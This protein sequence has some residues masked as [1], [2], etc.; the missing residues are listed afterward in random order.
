MSIDVHDFLPYYPNEIEDDF[1]QNIYD[2]KEFYD[3]R[4]QL[5]EINLPNQAKFELMKHQIIGNRYINSHTPYDRLFVNHEMG[6]GKCVLGETKITL[7]DNSTITIKELW[8]K[9]YDQNNVYLQTYFEDW[10]VPK[11]SIYVKAFDTETLNTIESNVIKLYRQYIRENIVVVKTNTYSISMT[12]A[13]KIFTLDGWKS[14]HELQL[15]MA[16]ATMFKNVMTFEAIRAIELVNY[17]G[18]VYDLEIDTYHTYIANHIITHNTCYAI[19]IIKE[20]MQI[21]DTVEKVYILSNSDKLCNNFK[22]E[23]LYKCVGNFQLDDDNFKKI[24]KFNTFTKF[25]KQ[26]KFLTNDQLNLKFS[27]TIFILDEVHH[28]HGNLTHEKKEKKKL[29]E[30]TYEQIHRLLHA[31]ENSRQILLSGTAMQNSSKE[32]IQIMN[33][34]LPLDYQLDD[35]FFIRY[36]INDYHIKPELLSDFKNHFKGNVTYLRADKSIVNVIEISNNLIPLQ[37]EFIKWATHNNIMSKFQSEIY[38]LVRRKIN[39]NNEQKNSMYSNDVQ[40]TLYVCDEDINWNKEE[41]GFLKKNYLIKREQF[42]QQFEKDKRWK[43]Q[44]EIIDYLNEH[45]TTYFQIIQYILNSPEELI[46]VYCNLVVGSGLKT[47][48]YFLSKVGFSEFIL[49]DST[50][51]V[52]DVYKYKLK[53]KEKR[54]ISTTRSRKYDA[55]RGGL[56]NLFEENLKYGNQ[57]STQ[58]LS[59]LIEVFNDP[60]NVNGE[61]I[62]II[63]GSEMISEGFSLKNIQQ[64]HIA[65]P[66]WNWAQTSQAIARGLRAHSHDELLKF[67]PDKNINVKLFLHA[68]IPQNLQAISDSI[69]LYK[70]QIS[71]EK[72]SGILE[73]QNIIREMSFDCQ[74]N[75]Y[76]NINHIP[77]QC[78]GIINIDPSNNLDYSTYNLYYVNLTNIKNQIKLYFKEFFIAHVKDIFNYLQQYDKTINYFNMCQALYELIAQNEIVEN[79][80]E[81][82]CFLK[83]ENNILYL[84]PIA[85]NEN[86]MLNNYYT[87]NPTILIPVKKKELI[88]KMYFQNVAKALQ[89]FNFTEN[90]FYNILT[91][92]MVEYLIEQSFLIDGFKSKQIQNY[93]SPYLKDNRNIIISTYLQNKE[94][95][96]LRCMDKVTKIWADCDQNVMQIEIKETEKQPIYGIYKDKKFCIKYDNPNLKTTD[97]R[98]HSKGRNCET[99]KIGDLNY[100]L[101]ELKLGK[102]HRM[103]VSEFQK[104]YTKMSC[105]IFDKKPINELTQNEKELF[106]Y[107]FKS[108]ATKTSKC[109]LI[110]DEFKNR[111]LI[112]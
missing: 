81:L 33:L 10:I 26:L 74:L 13:H 64:I 78:S 73:V 42:F 97:K 46:F 58:Q 112:R 16:V 65:T 24:Y 107:W 63:A 59:K 35:S 49:D 88:K 66:A 99:C 54:F 7:I 106:A 36:A 77:Y 108:S 51:S 94:Q 4:I 110:E 67:Y 70:Y 101:V 44:N 6:T 72:D 43:D 80:Y 56:E 45:S 79:R 21:D 82:N 29:H 111:K 39:V 28:L 50:I 52:D 15:D 76:R 38:N 61:Y 87:I 31:I 86:V 75:Y 84:S 60:R 85:I 96:P 104:L 71:S 32:I 22:N 95:Q 14:Y 90:N 34:I 8:E 48:I 69:D 105:D 92:K 53:N 27:N 57:Y 12:K 93:F 47:F 1:Y 100:L 3:Y 109:Q 40:T 30:E 102:P 20:I 83:N 37:N 23:L 11:N 91:S 55:E 41:Q 62:Q 9:N 5:N 68:A 18:F 89:N 2:K 25:A 98:E 103:A 19:G 17:D